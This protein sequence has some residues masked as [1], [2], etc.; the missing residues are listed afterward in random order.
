MLASM[1]IPSNTAARLALLPQQGHD[2]T[3]YQNRLLGVAQETDHQTPRPI[4][5][6]P[7]AV[8]G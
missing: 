1:G 6:P 7:T 8:R 5:F 4:G 3:L 2:E